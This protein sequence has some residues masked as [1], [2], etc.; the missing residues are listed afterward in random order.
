MT[1]LRGTPT[2]LG[3]ISAGDGNVELMLLKTGGEIESTH[4]KP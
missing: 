4:G 3:H 1:L 2:K